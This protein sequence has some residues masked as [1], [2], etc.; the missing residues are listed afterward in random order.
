MQQN[1]S[2]PMAMP[3]DL[4]PL[5]VKEQALIEAIGEGLNNSEAYQRAYG[6][7]GYS[8]SALHVRACEK[9]A[10]PK[11]QAHLQALR[12]V[13]FTKAVVSRQGRLEAELAFAARC[14]ATGNYGAAGQTYDRINKLAGYY[15]DGVVLVQPKDPM[16]TLTELAKISPEAAAALATKAGI[17]QWQPSTETLQ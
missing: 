9:V 3:D 4:P 12:Q 11:I 1:K 15:S 7:E 16:E 13:G 5:S 2:N 17:Q 6:A 14:E 8:R 10:E